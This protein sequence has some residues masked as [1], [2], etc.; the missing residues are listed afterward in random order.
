M[1]NLTDHKWKD[2]L[3]GVLVQ[4]TDSHGHR[5]DV[6]VAIDA[7]GEEVHAGGVD[8]AGAVVGQPRT[9]FFDAFALDQDVGFRRVSGRYH[10]AV[11]D[12]SV[13]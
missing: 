8:Y 12:E 13:H 1:V 6:S 4:V 2:S 5:T 7:A 9:D 11:A 10:R 3:L